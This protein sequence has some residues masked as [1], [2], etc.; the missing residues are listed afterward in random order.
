MPN[1]DIIKKINFNDSFRNQNIINNFDLEDV[2][3][4][5]EFKGE[6]PI[7]NEEW[8]IGLIVGGSGSGKTVIA[9]ECFNLEKFS[10]HNFGTESVIDEMPKE[11]TVSEITN[12]FNAVGFGSVVSW[13]KPYNVLS[14][15]EKMRVDLAYNLLSNE[16][17]IIFDEF[18]SVVDRDIAKTT[19]LAV[20]KNVRRNNK[21]FIAI[22]C[23][24]DIIEW[25]Q[26]NWVYNTDTNNFF[27][28]MTGKN[29]SLNYKFIKSQTNWVR[30]YGKH[31]VN[32]TI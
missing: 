10:N 31:L 4:Q 29:Q 32:I 2:K 6:I 24:F 3:F 26:P 21:K 23:H 9:K 11:C 25:L 5:E 28:K 8:N 19:S 16:D 15:G 30:E 13:L 1:F 17:L 27:L 7:E 22:S 18:T 12:M 20:Q 14:N